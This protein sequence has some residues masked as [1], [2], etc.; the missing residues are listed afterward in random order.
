MD[1]IILDSYREASRTALEEARRVHG[2]SRPEFCICEYCNRLKMA[3]FRAE[4][5]VMQHI[6]DLTSN[7]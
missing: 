7:R 6:E 2:G 4:F 5:A 1:Y 3:R